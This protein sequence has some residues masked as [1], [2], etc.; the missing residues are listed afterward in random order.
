[1]FKVYTKIVINNFSRV[2]NKINNSNTQKWII[3]QFKFDQYKYFFNS[4]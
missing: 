2:Q 3:N 4:F 1:M